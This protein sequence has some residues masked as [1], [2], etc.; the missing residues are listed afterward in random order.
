MPARA[1]CVPRAHVSAILPVRTLPCIPAELT[2]LCR[3]IRYL[4]GWRVPIALLTR[5]AMRGFFAASAA[6][7]KRCMSRMHRIF[8]GMRRPQKGNTEA[9]GT[10]RGAKRSSV[11]R[12]RMMTPNRKTPKKRKNNCAKRNITTQSVISL[13]AGEY[14]CAKGRAYARP[15][16][17][18]LYGVM[19]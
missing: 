1:I 2:C 8:C 18:I 6:S 14:H 19:I 10:P 9:S 11:L 16:A 13:A 15:F 7:H 4:A 5:Y 17:H 3:M 12:T